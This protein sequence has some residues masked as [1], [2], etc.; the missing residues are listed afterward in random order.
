MDSNTTFVSK[1]GLQRFY[2][3]IYEVFADINHIHTGLDVDAATVDSRGT[4]QPDGSTIKITNAGIISVPIVTDNTNGL[5][6]FSDKN[7]LD[8]IEDNANNYTHP[9]SE[10]LAD[11]YGDTTNQTPTFGETFKTI[12][13][14]VDE[15]GHVT[16]MAEHTITIPTTEATTSTAGLMS[17]TDKIKL[18]TLPDYAL[19]ESPSFTGHPTAP[20]AAKGTNTSQIATTAF[21]KAAID[22]IL[23]FDEVSY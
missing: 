1:V 17:A 20:T 16:S 22:S 15:Q 5:M 11:S 6:S 13:Q 3:R 19:L 21:V 7:R 10:V 23:V 12:S 18:E 8:G 9:D 4:V 14:T 2:A